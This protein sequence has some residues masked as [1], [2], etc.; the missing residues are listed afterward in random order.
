M[1]TYFAE[2]E[3]DLGGTNR[4]KPKKYSRYFNGYIYT[5]MLPGT[6][7]PCE[8]AEPATLSPGVLVAKKK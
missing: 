3:F 5:E 8:F 6:K 1:V 2:Y 4:I 7:P